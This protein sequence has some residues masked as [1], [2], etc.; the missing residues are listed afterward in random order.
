MTLAR[1]RGGPLNRFNGTFEWAAFLNSY[2]R[3]HCARMIGRLLDQSSLYNRKENSVST[4][5]SPL[6]RA[7]PPHE[8]RALINYLNLMQI[9]KRT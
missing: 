3:N 6:E 7:S 1:E 9:E 2:L 5:V 4:R 8:I